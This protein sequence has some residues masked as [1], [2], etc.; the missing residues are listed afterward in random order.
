MIKLP[1]VSAD[2][3]IVGQGFEQVWQ[4]LGIIHTSRRILEET[5]LN[6]KKKIYLGKIRKYIFQKIRRFGQ[7]SNLKYFKCV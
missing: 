1:S 4:G 7:K 3:Y 6:R 2:I 5:L